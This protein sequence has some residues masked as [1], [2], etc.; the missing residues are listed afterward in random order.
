MLL[1]ETES[2]KTAKRKLEHIEIVLTKPVEGPMTTWFE[3]VF[4]PQRALP[5]VD[6]ER[7]SVN[8]DFLGKE[9]SAPLMI[10][11]MT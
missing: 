2:E 8:V 10:T 4:L 9:I 11:G 1:K 6:P 7:V 3:Y 5:V